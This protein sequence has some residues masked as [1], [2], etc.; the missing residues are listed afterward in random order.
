MFVFSPPQT[1]LYELC[2]RVD[3]VWMSRF[4]GSNSGQ[5]SKTHN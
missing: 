3:E 2:V 4:P 1:G 5:V